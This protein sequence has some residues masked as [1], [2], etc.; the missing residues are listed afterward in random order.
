VSK[1]K[2]KDP[3][4]GIEFEMKH[5]EIKNKENKI[6][7]S[8]NI[9][10]PKNFDDGHAA[11]VAS[12]YLCNNAKLKET[13]LKQMIDRVSDTIT[14]WAREQGYFA[15]DK[16]QY[17][18]FNYKLK[19]YQIHQYFAFNSPVYFNIGLVDDPQSSACFIL[20][21]DDDMKSIFEVAG[22]EAEIF[23]HGSGT[24]MNISP[25]RSSKETVARGGK[26]SGPCSFLR[27]HDIDAGTIK[28]GGTLRRSAKM[29]CMNI[30]HPDIEEFIEVKDHEEEKLRILRDAGFKPRDGYEMSDEV[31]YQNTNISVRLSDNFMDAAEKDNDWWTTYVK[32]GELCKKYK[33]R[34]LMVKIAEHAWKTGDPGI[35]F[36]DTFNNWHTCINSGEI[37]ST[38][39]CLPIWAP[40]LT[41]NGYRYFGQ[42]RNKIFINNKE[43]ECSDVIKTKSNEKVYE[44]ELKNGM[45]IYATKDHL[46]KT[47]REDVELQNLKINDQIKMCYDKISY[48]FNQD[49]YEKGFIAG[50]L[51]SD[52]SIINESSGEKFINFSLGI[53]EF[54]FEDYFEKLLKKHIPNI[55]DLKYTPHYQKPDTCYDFKIWRKEVVKYI[56][57]NIFKSENKDS[58]NLLE[59]N[60]SISYQ[61]GFVE[62][63]ITFDG[64]VLNRKYNKVIKINQSGDRGYTILKQ[65]QLVLASLGIYGN[66]TI[67]NH[68]K[69]IIRDEKECHY[70]TSW[71][72]EVPDIWEFAKE[73]KLYSPEKQNR[74]EQIISVPKKH[75]TR[76]TNLK[77][78][79]QIKNIRLFSEEDVYDINVP[80]L[81]YFVTC[82]AVVHN[83]GEFSFIDNS[84]CNLAAINLLKFFIKSIFQFDFDYATFKDVVETMIT[85]QD[86]LINKSSYPT[87]E[88]KNNTINFR[89]LGA[90]FTNLGALL[91]YLGLPYDSDEGRTITSLLTA[92]ETSIAYETSVRLAVGL[93][94]FKGF[95]ENQDTFYNVLKQ[96]YVHFGILCANCDRTEL[97]NT[98][99]RFVEIS[100]NNIKN[101]IENNAP[102]RNATTTLIAPT[103]TTSSLM[104]AFTTG[105]EPEFSLI[106][107]K[108]LSGSENAVLKFV[109][110]IVGVALRNLGYNEHEI[111]FIIKYIEEN[112]HVDDCEKLK[113]EHLPIFDT[114]MA[115]RGCNRMID[116]MG[117][118][119]MCAAIQ[120]FISMAISKTI[121]LPNSATVGDIYN[122]YI[123]AWKMGLKGITIYRDGSK[124]FQPLSANKEEIEI[125]SE[126]SGEWSNAFKIDKSDLEE[127]IKGM[128]PKRRK[129]PDE[130][131]AFRH[132][133]RIGSIEGYLSPGLYDNG[134]LGEIFIDLAKEGT[135]TSG[136][137]DSIATITSIAI[138]YGVPLKDLV[139]KMMYRRFDP[140]GFTSNPDIRSCTSIVDYIF[141]YLGM[142][143]LSEEDKRELGLLLVEKET[144]E[145]EINITY[146]SHQDAAPTCPSCGSFM[147]ILGSCWT[148]TQ[149]A[150]SEGSCG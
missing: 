29:V 87:E 105:C 69:D 79:Q 138:Q 15:D 134:E 77:E 2:S 110:P 41:P 131:V 40:V 3:Y 89:P 11:I 146:N 85:A 44:V 86:I 81:S 13:S 27:C 38:N 120:P 17:N 12:R 126:N 52:G 147:R 43:Y 130:R 104:E 66:L 50:Y 121:N 68:E 56:L 6:T 78:Y 70:Q 65:I 49:E 54:E 139:D 133:F 57:T 97:I 129:L 90:G 80:N 24:G 144:I 94:E 28:S 88:I 59:E 74:I 35:M 67:S 60:K 113:P 16:T 47:N 20:K 108:T 82:G 124:S 1:N 39:P 75:P 31:F 135:L 8:E 96:H 125:I 53:E 118:V 26:A 142:K 92:L 19:Y 99:I 128:K 149:C 91:M 84:S 127:A 114:S 63:F 58:F 46:I 45:C 145:K 42:L 100:Q 115:P 9:A 22:I 37:N 36:S 73:F 64:H 103:G 48:E 34:D 23:K 150:W 132:K 33:A 10:F 98:L 136:M 107:Y 106:R 117:H 122:L 55:S 7:F 72:I 4:E 102:F 95:K 116:Y 61:K 148:C 51:F 21:I 143:Y 123:K 18:E 111:N 137:V 30:D 32:T 109:N 112:G 5:I 140:S 76:I 14:N 83:C 62:A 101:F 71:V 25:L 141:R 93:G 119:K